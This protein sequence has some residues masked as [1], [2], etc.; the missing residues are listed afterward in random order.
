MTLFRIASS[1][2]IWIL[3][4]R[5]SGGMAVDLGFQPNIGQTSPDATFIA[6]RSNYTAFLAPTGATLRTR[7]SALKMSFLG[8]NPRSE[9]IGLDPTKSLV[10]YL[11][12]NR[13][14]WHTDVPTYS[15]V[16]Y[17][18]VYA[19]INISYYEAHG[20]LGY[21]F[22]LNPGAE[23]AQIRLRFQGGGR[24]QLDPNG[25][26]V[27]QASQ[28]EWRHTR[29]AVYQ[30]RGGGRRKV[31]GHFI[32]QGSDEVVFEAEDYDHSVPLTI[33]MALTYSTYLGGSG[34]DAATSI[35]TD[36][37]GN[38]YVT[39]WSESLDFPEAAGARLGSPGGVDV[40]VAKLN[41]AGRL[42]Y[43]TYI[44]GSGDDQG[45]GI[46]VDNSGAAVIVGST[47]STNF[48][49]VNA[50]QP[51]PGGGRDSFVAKLNAAG[52]ALSFS[53][54][55]GGSGADN[56]NGVSLDQQ[57]NI[58]IAGETAS[59]NFP[60]LNAF[61][62]QLGGGEDAFV[63]KLSGTGVLL[64]STYIGGVADDRATAVAVDALGN[65]YITG[66]TYSSNFP[67]MSAFQSSLGGGQDAFAVKVGPTGST[68]VYSTYLGG[69]GGTVGAPEAG[70]GIAVDLLGSA[71]IAGTTS[72]SN[73][74]TSNPMQSSLA[75]SQDAF[76]LKMGPSGNALVYSTYLGG[77]SIDM[78]TAITIDGTGRA[79]VAGYTASTDFPVANA[80]QPSNAGSYD[81]FI[82]RLNAG[83]S[84]IELG[85]YLG[86]AGSDSAYGIVLDANNNLYVA[87]QT[88]SNNFPTLNALQVSEPAPAS[89]L[90]SEIPASCSFALDQ[91]AYVVGAAGGVVTAYLT[92]TAG[93]PWTVTNNYPAAITITMG[94][95]G[96]GNG[97][98]HLTIAP[99]PAA[100]ARTFYLPLGTTQIQINQSGALQLVAVAPCRIMDT[101]N[102]NGPLGGPYI[103]AGTIR[104]IP[105]S[106]SACGIP[107]S[108][109]AYSLNI[110]VVPRTGTLGY[111][112]IWPAGQPQ[113]SI[114]TLNS[115]DG[116]VLA[117]AAIVPA[118]A[119]GSIN[120]YA[121]NDT[122]LIVD[123]NGYFAPPAMGTL[124]FFPLTPCRILDTRN[125]N[126][127]FGGPSF[128]DGASRSVPIVSSGCG[129]PIGAAAYSLNLTVV[130]QGLL[131]YLTVWPTGQAQPA[132][133]T[134]NSLDGTVL[135][136]AAIVPA[137]TNGAVSF[138]ASNATDVVVDI[139]GYF[140]PP[141]TGGLN[142]YTT[143]PCRIVDTRNPAGTFGGPILNAGTTRT[144]PLSQGACGLPANS[145]AY[146]L[147]VTVVPSGLLGY[148]TT[149]PTG[150]SQPGVSTLNALKGQVVANAAIV[151]AG[152][153]G[154]VNVYVMNT[155]HL[156]IDTDGYFAQ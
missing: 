119:N 16:E 78:A 38:V 50:A 152:A 5:A 15:R 12:G 140:A 88:L 8:A 57:G 63:A 45:Y 102:P 87:G 64:Y 106:A 31:A 25:D 62:K 21:A 10:H 91:N 26:L 113:P 128:A 93:C 70:N 132:V 24:V 74:P 90:V 135:A 66:S 29:A 137:G 101:R 73:F 110:T 44:G 94:A 23:P 43:V 142:F 136:N 14:Q 155:A 98:I 139:N 133:S 59:A 35:A 151:P 19:N 47:Y 1:V 89:A 9:A 84:A 69:S 34:Q 48:P 105:V 130:P 77:S 54:Y 82:V 143:T 122:E 95:S 13:E 79:Y 75:G 83:G 149:W 104:T 134:L 120:A 30:V 40:Y 76:V 138:Y 61:Q 150:G 115:L 46:A 72:S 27:L 67:V 118:G 154:S 17:R 99:Y 49:I 36:L 97:T 20:S 107:A 18:D 116:S 127:I 86:G 109:V 124:Q 42:I 148:L 32:V 80:V 52:S 39:G 112:T 33:D 108:A 11:L 60:V 55:V 117:N 153:S 2:F 4:C 125:P 146:A 114:S 81:A 85:T 147:N 51:R 96:T 68:L 131:G 100:N 92:A 111:L 141:G 103:A 58:Y 6:H 126:G 41:P 22:I 145:A 37:N 123:V 28:S 71:Y 7:D 65:A 156:I 129:V 144:F 3:V 121:M 56:A 53:T